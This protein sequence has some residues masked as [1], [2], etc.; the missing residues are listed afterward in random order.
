M[1]EVKMEIIS[2]YTQYMTTEQREQLWKTVSKMSE[3][4]L[5][6]FRCSF[7]QES[8]GFSGKESV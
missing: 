1:E 2:E 7:D 8:M 5:K 3:A 6:E 4:E